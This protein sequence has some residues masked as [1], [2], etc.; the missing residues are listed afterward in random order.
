MTRSAPTAGCSP[1]SAAGG[2]PKPPPPARLLGVA[3]STTS[4]AARALPA[5]LAPLVLF[6][7]I[8]VWTPPHFWAL[9]VKSRDA[10]AAA[11]VPMLP[12]VMSIKKTA[13]RI[14]AYTIALWATSLLLAPVAGLGLLYTAVALGLG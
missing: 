2:L 12:A 7:I 11:D 13:T 9:A 3:A 4:L 1:A 14:V 8:F 10:C 6:A 5:G